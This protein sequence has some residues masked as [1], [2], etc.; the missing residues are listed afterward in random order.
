M[1]VYDFTSNYGVILQN[2]TADFSGGYTTVQTLTLDFDSNYFASVPQTLDFSSN[3]GVRPEGERVADFSS[4]YIAYAPLELPQI[5]PTILVTIRGEPLDFDEITDQL[6][7]SINVSGSGYTCSITS[8]SIPRDLTLNDTISVVVGADRYEFLFDRLDI[9]ED[10]LE[11][12]SVT[13]SGVSP[14]LA[15]GLPRSQAQDFTNNTA[16]LASVIVTQLIGVV[17]WQIVDWVIPEFRLGVNQQTPLDIARSVVDA[18]GGI[19]NSDRLGNPVVKYQYPGS[20]N[21][22]PTATPHPKYNTFDH[23]FSRNHN[24]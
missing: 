16:T 3:Y 12:A 4:A 15:F 17:D 19:L 11:S 8:A 7:I 5:P 1:A 20:T 10:G 13:L 21:D 22:Y 24:L 14:L 23:E 9:Q 18:A 2:L 6:S